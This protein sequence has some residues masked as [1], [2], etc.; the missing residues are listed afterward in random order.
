MAQ[1]VKNLAVIILLAGFILS[2]T[3]IQILAPKKEMS[4]SERRLLAGMPS[5]T[6]DTVLTGKFMSEFETFAQD[7]FPFRDSFRTVKT[8]SAMY[9]FGMKQMHELYSKDGYLVKIEYPLSDHMIENAAH[10]FENIYNSFLKDKNVRIYSS[11]IPDKNYF[12]A[13]ESGHMSMDYGKLVENFCEQTPYMEYIDIFDLLSIEDYYKT[14]TH[15]RQENLV[16]V[17]ERLAGRMGVEAM[18]EDAYD[19]MSLN[20]PFYGVYAGQFALPTEADT[21]IY[22]TNNILN[23]CVVTSYDTGLPKTSSMYNF[24]KAGGR[25]PYEFFLSGSDAL[26]VIENPNASTDRELV[27]FRDSF[28]SSLTPLLAGAYAKVTLVDIRYIQSEML[29][30]FIEFDNQ[31]VLFLYST[32]ILN[33]STSFR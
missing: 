4:E 27:I 9:L 2:M 21:I 18:A 33:N 19:V 5:L 15:W 13:N 22:L 6:T 16:P 17:A 8:G 3:V 20:I 12:L 11:I 23:E 24:E 30:Y 7:Q 32:L 29:E 1:R 26:L 14:D 25:D 31:D 10:K 28:G